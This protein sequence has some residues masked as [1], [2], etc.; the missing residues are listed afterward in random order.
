MNIN[1]KIEGIDGLEKTL[2]GMS[3]IRWTS[4]VKKT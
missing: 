2:N 3:S 1:M 4:I